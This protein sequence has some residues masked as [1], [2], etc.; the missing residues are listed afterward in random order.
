[1]IKLLKERIEKIDSFEKHLKTLRVNL[2][3]NLI[4]NKNKI[5]SFF[6]YNLNFKDCGISEINTETFIG[7]TN[8]KCLDLENND[9][10]FFDLKILDNLSEIEKSLYDNN[11][12]MNKDAISEIP[13]FTF[14][15]K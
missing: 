10:R 9:I 2:N 13:I 6:I 12:I 5:F 8:L 11:A 3:T 1:M 14:N 15:S 4:A 7:L